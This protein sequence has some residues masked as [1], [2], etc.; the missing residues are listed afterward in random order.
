MEQLIEWIKENVKE[1]ADLS[2][3]SQM[4]ESLN[5]VT[6]ERAAELA[7]HKEVRRILDAEI[8]RAVERHDERFRD[9]KLPKILDEERGK[10]R[11]ELNPEETPQ[12]KAVRELT[13]K[14]NRMEQEKATVERREQLRKKAQELGVSDIGLTPDDVEPFVSLGDNAGDVL[15]AFVNRTKE[16]W[17]SSLDAKLKEKYSGKAPEASPETDRADGPRGEEYVASRLRDTFLG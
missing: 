1:G 5:D 16:A 6:P 11:Q 13:E 14:L 10:I 4:V 15:E 9:E 17:T 8:S 7:K 3:V 2:E 12:D